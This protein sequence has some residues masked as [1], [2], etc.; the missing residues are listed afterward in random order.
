MPFSSSEKAKFYC[1]PCSKTS[2]SEIWIIFPPLHDS[3][4]LRPLILRIY[5][6]T[7]AGRKS[8]TSSNILPSCSHKR[9]ECC[10]SLST[11]F[12]IA[13]LLNCPSTSSFS[14]SL[15]LG[16]LVQQVSL[17]F[18]ASCFCLHPYQR[19]KSVSS[20]NYKVAMTFDPF[21]VSL[22]TRLHTMKLAS[23]LRC[24]TA[25]G[26]SEARKSFR[27]TNLS[28]VM[29]LLWAESFDMKADWALR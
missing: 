14:S 26:E 2:Q 8:V 10:F 21:A 5:A 1:S 11:L 3:R 28:R 19:E 24:M 23:S 4:S 7:I 6:S 20:E 22:L 27:S 18:F 29:V 9:F 13:L 12:F 25:W 15:C 16:F 17:L